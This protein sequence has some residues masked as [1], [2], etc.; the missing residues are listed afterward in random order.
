MPM[1]KI[2]SAVVA[3][4]YFSVNCVLAHSTE[5]NFWASRRA[6]SQQV[7]GETAKLEEG[8]TVQ[9]GNVLLAQLPMAS[10]VDLARGKAD[11]AQASADVART[12][13]S[14]GPKTGDWLGKMVSPYGSVRDVYLSPLKDAP[15][16]VHIQD[17]HGIEEAQRNISSMIEIMGQEPKIQLVGLEAA[18]GPFSL[19]PYRDYPD[20]NIT[21]EIA[22][23]FLKKGLIAGP[24]YAGLVLSKSPDFF[25]AEDKTLY[26][27]NVLALKT[28]YKNK[29]TVQTQMGVVLN[30]V[31]ALKSVLYSEQLKIFDA[32]FEGYHSEK[33]KLAVYV[34]Y[35]VEINEVVR[36]VSSVPNLE[37]LVRAL[38]EEDRLNFKLVEKERRDLVEQLANKLNVQQMQDLVA[39]SVDYRAGRVGYG[40][41]HS[42][43]IDVCRQHGIGVGQWAHLNRYIS[44]V[45]LA[46]KIDKNGLLEE[47]D[48]LDRSIPERLAKT[49][50]EKKLVS[51]VYDLTLMAKLLRHEMAPTDWA[52]Y[53][54]RVGEIHRLGDRL[55]ELDPTGKWESLSAK[56]LKPFEDFCRYATQRNNALTD[57]LLRRM[58]ETQAKSAVLVAGGFH[59][60]GLSALLR[61]KQVSYVVVTPKITEIPRDNKYLDLLASDPVPLEK[62]LAGDRIYL[63]KVVGMTEKSTAGLMAAIQQVAQLKKA[64]VD[65]GNGY[66]ITTDGAYPGAKVLF[67]LSDGR[68]IYFVTNFKQEKPFMNFTSKLVNGSILVVK[69]LS[70]RFLSMVNA[71]SLPATVKEDAIMLLGALGLIGGPLVSFAILLLM[72]IPNLIRIVSDEDS[73]TGKR[74]LR[75]V[76]LFSA[77]TILQ[78]LWVD[79][80]GSLDTYSNLKA[81]EIA[82]KISL[83]HFLYSHVARSLNRFGIEP[84]TADPLRSGPT[85]YNTKTFSV[86]DALDQQTPPPP[87]TEQAEMLIDNNKNYIVDLKQ[88]PVGTI[89]YYEIANGHWDYTIRIEKNNIVSVWLRSDLG[90]GMGPITEIGAQTIYL[91]KDYKKV[92]MM[93]EPGIIRT[94]RHFCMPYFHQTQFGA[95]ERNLLSIGDKSDTDAFIAGPQRITIQLPTGHLFDEMLANNSIII[96]DNNPSLL[97]LLNRTFLAIGHFTIGKFGN[98]W[99]GWRQAWDLAGD[100]MTKKTFS[101]RWAPITELPGLPWVAQAFGGGVTAILGSSFIFALLHHLRPPPNFGAE[102]HEARG[103]IAKASVIVRA[104]WNT[105]KMSIGQFFKK[106]A[107]R[108]S[109]S[110]E[111]GNLVFGVGIQLIVQALAA[112]IINFSALYI[113]GDSYLFTGLVAAGLHST[114]NFIFPRFGLPALTA[115]GKRENLKEPPDEWT[116]PRELTFLTP[117]Q[118]AV[119]LIDSWENKEL[120]VFHDLVELRHLNRNSILSIINMY[121]DEREKQIA[122]IRGELGAFINVSISPITA[123][124]EEIPEISKIIASS[125]EFIKALTKN[126][127][128]LAVKNMFGF[129]LAPAEIQDTL[130]LEFIPSTG[131]HKHVFKAKIN[132]VRGPV[133]SL[134]IPFAIL[135]EEKEDATDQLHPHIGDKEFEDLIHLRDSGLVPHVGL[136]GEMDNGRRIIIEPF[137]NGETVDQLIRH[138]QLNNKLRKEITL[139]LFKI[140]DLI[141]DQIPFDA[142]G[143]NF[144]YDANK[145]QMV[146]VD[147]GDL[148]ADIGQQS[149]SDEAKA[150]TMAAMMKNILMDYGD[151]NGIKFQENNALFSGILLANRAKGLYFLN[152]IAQLSSDPT[153]QMDLN[154]IKTIEITR[155]FVRHFSITREG[156]QKNHIA[157]SF[158]NFF[159]EGLSL[160]L[161]RRL[162]IEWGM[163]LL[164]VEMG[165]IVAAGWMAP[166]WVAGLVPAMV[167]LDPIA[168]GV[169]GALGM[170]MGLA[171]FKASHYAFQY[172]RFYLLNKGEK[173]SVSLSSFLRE[174]RVFVPYVALPLLIHSTVLFA[175]VAAYAAWRHYSFDVKVLNQEKEMNAAALKAV[176]ALMEGKNLGRVPETLKGMEVGGYRSA[177]ELLKTASADDIE[178]AIR[179]L[180]KESVTVDAAVEYGRQMALAEGTGTQKVAVLHGIASWEEKTRTIALAVVRGML[181]AGKPVL[182]VAE[183]GF[184]T[185]IIN[186]SGQTPPIEVLNI[187]ELT[188]D[189]M[190]TVEYRRESKQVPLATTVLIRKED[191]AV[192]DGTNYS[193][194]TFEGISRAIQ[195]AL[196]NFAAALRAA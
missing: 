8:D 34:R 43:L 50:A 153:S 129:N 108:V 161:P 112:V 47:M 144:I 18:W 17:G 186:Y 106:D 148:R 139:T 87:R 28:A 131:D 124:T 25:G 85:N 143:G 53:E 35:L 5:A 173:P 111:N 83:V 125:G 82:G 22:D 14:I 59:T 12:P 185:A 95:G 140:S 116:P 194:L 175:G 163:R 91:R 132:L 36:A 150:Y 77:L 7:K 26:D 100:S 117:N 162:A 46:D 107:W 138:G 151:I 192:L 62:Q 56:T 181:M 149:S 6:A 113:G 33:E 1:R 20:A 63:A 128:A 141:N 39:K 58:G 157:T 103:A 105:I 195:N 73:S 168:L 90:R 94:D 120:N 30:N 193:A 179:V 180:E 89:V 44:Y 68:K 165:G 152:Q 172:A 155:D 41:Y 29:Q 48:A 164:P 101:Y 133:R 52:A 99:V 135:K 189:L 182:I 142:H 72:H 9:R 54:K 97:S 158:N 27:A 137:I 114:Y 122:G 178:S 86:P 147:L 76:T 154:L 23:F 109:R 146:M 32:H 191:S 3:A 42:H 127:L 171:L 121:G 84:A 187:A 98:N 196:E 10:P 123:P 51:V 21:K 60:E 66:A 160:V 176:I 126:E 61:Q 184:E 183:E 71:I 15:F 49:A 115:G 67:E 177:G 170:A 104:V 130:S 188:S 37:L 80:A 159:V 134:E 45:M 156:I 4:V 31:A 96:V 174:F 119:A 93:N 16:I 74:I 69:T 169:V 166:V 110:G 81:L 136:I 92:N 13:F 75:L 88:L 2:L 19:Q 40:D 38:D 118:L 190:D 167:G 70:I 55:N 79:W 102:F 11:T 64:L 57:N 65:M 78:L 24:E 145:K